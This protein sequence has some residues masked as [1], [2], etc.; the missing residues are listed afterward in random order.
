MS[1]GRPSNIKKMQNCI[2]ASL[3]EGLFVGLSVYPRIKSKKQVERTHLLVDQTC[4]WAP[5]LVMGAPLCW[6]APRV[7][8][9]SPGL[10][11]ALYTSIQCYLYISIWKGPQSSDISGGCFR[12]SIFKIYLYCTKI[13]FC[14]H[15]RD[16]DNNISNFNTMID[17]EYFK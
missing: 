15:C 1:S 10:T 9:G 11:M 3:Q 12:R 16:N 2:L 14:I 4:F 13:L 5:W 6:G 7:C 8:L 17:I